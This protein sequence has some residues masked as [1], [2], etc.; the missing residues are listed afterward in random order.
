M[1]QGERLK[2]YRINMLGATQEEISVGICSRNM[3]SLIENNKQKL[4]YNLA[5]RIAE[6][7]NKIAK[8]KGMDIFL[9][10]PKELMI[11]EDEQAN[12]VFQNNILNELQ[13]IEIG[14]LEINLLEKKISESEELIKKYSIADNKKIEFYKLTAD[15]YYYKYI[16]TKSDYMCDMGLKISI[17]SQYKVGEVIFYIYKSRN[18]IF[19]DKYINALQQLDY[20]EKLNNDIGNNELYEMIFYYK[21]LA[22]KKLGQYDSALKYFKILKEQFQI[23]DKRML[24]KIKMVYANCL[25]DQNKFDESEK[26]YKE[27]LNMAM[28]YDDKDFI[29]MT[30]RNL[31]ELYVNKKNYKS[32]AKYIKE[33]LLYNPNNEDIGEYLYFAAKIFQNLN[34]DIEHYLLQALDICEKKD[35]ENLNLILK[36]LYELV[37]IYINKDDEKN[38]IMM[39]EKAK[40]LNTD[41]SLIYAEVGEYYRVTNEEKSK[42]YSRKSIDKIKTIKKI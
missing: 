23:K 28:K 38:L 30:Y 18:N 8:K 7:L 29:T 42:Y 14:S 1:M 34:E 21:A 13:K 32:A 37:L 41:Y 40:E 4:S 3:I 15:F 16:H 27:T 22:Y 24:L 17:D 35:K 31:S 12:Y 2:K 20:A 33:S 19:S 10:T 11:D 6:N 36:I 39:V 5:Y 9:I 25:N 26:E